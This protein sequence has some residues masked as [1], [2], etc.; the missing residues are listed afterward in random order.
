MTNKVSKIFVFFL[1]LFLPIIIAADSPNI[2]INEVAW[3]GTNNSANDEW[4]ELYNNSSFDLDLEGWKL[5][6]EDGTPVIN[7]VGK[8]P[9]KS[10]FLLERTDDEPLPDIKADLIYK[11]SLNNK[12]EYLKIAAKD[13]KIIDEIDCSSE[14]FAGNN[15]TKQTMERKDASVSGNDSQNWQTSQNPGGTPKNENSIPPEKLPEDGHRIT[16]KEELEEESMPVSYPTG[17]V[18]NEIL[19]SPEGPDA[20]NEWI[21]P[22]KQHS[23]CLQL[24]S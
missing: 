11:G 9:T 4:I 17:I 24:L 18:F 23:L 1:T 8:I 12:G 22:T 15:E 16:E 2:V 20:E 13:G 5:I 21:V 6:A 19:P 3:M 10:F 14:W 7:L